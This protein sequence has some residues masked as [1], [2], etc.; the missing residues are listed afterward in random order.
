M[1]DDQSPNL[2]EQQTEQQT[3]NSVWQVQKNNQLMS[4]RYVFSGY[5][6]MRDFLDELETLSKSESYY[7]DLTF[8]RTHANV[9]IKARGKEL[10]SLD[11]NFSEKIDALFGAN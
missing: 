7:P 2:I 4:K 8:S 5:G 1:S 10:A 6:E 11:F 3:K 9:S